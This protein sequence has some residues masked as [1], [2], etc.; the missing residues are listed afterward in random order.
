MLKLSSN[1][2][3]LTYKYYSIDILR[4]VFCLEN[5]RYKNNITAS[6]A[7]NETFMAFVDAIVPRTPILAQIYGDIM[8]YG[9][10]DQEIDKYLLLNLDS[11]GAPFVRL[12]A[13][14]LNRAAKQYMEE[15]GTEKI[16]QYYRINNKRKQREPMGFSELPRRDRF[17]AL[18]LLDQIE[19]YFSNEVV[20]QYPRLQTITGVL[21]RFTMFGY[22]SEWYGYGTTRFLNPDQRILE[23]APMSW[24]QTN[25]PGPSLSYLEEVREYNEI[26]NSL[27]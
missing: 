6:Q 9:A 27:K 20:Q 4:Q 21:A 19:S 22:Y 26:K 17:R 24:Q 14:I 12:T 5:D 3:H 8:F 7:T 13:E 2:V 23:A 18:T 11:E 15:E 16:Y 25:Y 10:L 1:Q